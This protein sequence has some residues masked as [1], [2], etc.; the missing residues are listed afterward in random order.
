M[1]SL[2]LFI[3]FDFEEIEKSFLCFQTMKLNA[4]FL[5]KWNHLF[6]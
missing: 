4:A 5:T 3:D 2:L 6:F 1:K